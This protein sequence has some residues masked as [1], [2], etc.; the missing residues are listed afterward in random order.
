[1]KIKTLPEE[2]NKLVICESEFPTYE[3]VI[4][5][6]SNPDKID[7]TTVPFHLSGHMK[8]LE[9]GEKDR[10]IAGYASVIEVDQEE[11]L[12]PKETLENGIETLLSK[13]EYANLMLVHQNIQ[14]GQV[15][16]E[17]GDLKTHVDEKGLFIVASIRNDLETANEI[18][19]QILDNKLNGFSIA[20]EVLL[21]HD[22]CDKSKCI[23]VIDKINIF[24]ISVCSKP[25]NKKSGFMV[26]SKS[27]EEDVD[28]SDVCEICSIKGN[29]DMKKVKKAKEPT[30]EKPD[31]VENTEEKETIEEKTE[32]EPK[33]EEKAEEPEEKAKE[34]PKEEPEEEPKEE[35]KSEPEVPS[36]EDTIANLAR[37]VEALK[38]II[39]E[40]QEKQEKPEEE[41]PPEEED[42]EMP[43]PPVEE[44]KS[45]PEQE[46]KAEEIQTPS[47]SDFDTLKESVDTLIE[48]FSKIDELQKSIKSKDEQ[49]CSLNKRLEIIE[50]S[51]EKSKTL[52]DSEDEPEEEKDTLELIRDP[53]RT[54][55]IYRD[56]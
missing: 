38:G 42:E 28:T 30:E 22:E 45:E 18:W 50:K 29:Q 56:L 33:E 51:E 24:E 1:M 9:K 8:I 36:V 6:Y 11:Q 52:I 32:E 17:W 35:E 12:I 47:K 14:I 7:M 16:T 49:L 34:E 27:K 39:S 3:L 15:L 37:E 19:S 13:T 40:L 44:S 55:V 26:V 43:E 48:K 23:N 20:A 10:I 5:P 41:I 21:S 2:G 46:K 31:T 25:V 4:K 53:Y 54:G